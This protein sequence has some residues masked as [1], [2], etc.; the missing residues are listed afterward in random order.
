MIPG[1]WAR[2]AG[3][4]GM[5]ERHL[6]PTGTVAFL[7]TDIAGSTR[8]WQASERPWSGRMPRTMRSCATRLLPVFPRPQPLDRLVRGIVPRRA[9]HAAAR[10]GAGAACKPV[11]CNYTLLNR[12]LSLAFLVSLLDRSIHGTGRFIPNVIRRQGWT[13]ST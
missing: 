8:L 1:S 3:V 12:G 5:T 2:P 13:Y 9:H 10:P 6:L 11:S 7:F 4:L